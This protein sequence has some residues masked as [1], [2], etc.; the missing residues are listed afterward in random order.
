MVPFLI[1]WQIY[2]S[3]RQHIKPHLWVEQHEVALRFESKEHLA[4]LA[5]ALAVAGALTLRAGY[6]D[7]ELVRLAHA[8][9]LTA[10]GCGVL[11]APRQGAL[12]VA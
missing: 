4:F 3:Y 2:P 6:R 1:G 7:R 5:T 9:L 8:L 10:W 11:T 12:A